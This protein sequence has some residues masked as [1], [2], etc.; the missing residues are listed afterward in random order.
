MSRLFDA[1]TQ[2]S[3]DAAKQEVKR[4]AKEA[5]QAVLEAEELDA[6]SAKLQARLKNAES[7]SPIVYRSY[8]KPGGKWNIEY[9]T[10]GNDFIYQA[11]PLKPLRL[12]TPDILALMIQL[13]DGIFPSSVH[14]IYR[15]P[16]EQFSI[17][18]FTIR[19]TKVV[20]L[21]GWK[22]AVE[23]ALHGL[24]EIPAW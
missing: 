4:R 19:V 3:G 9:A 14:I 18:Y 11:I 8:R 16:S 1:G 10:D 13:M 20:G 6:A 12:V 22:A 7:V 2:A 21:P 15:P 23:R 17:K 24:A 5:A